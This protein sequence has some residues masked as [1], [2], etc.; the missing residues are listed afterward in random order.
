ML[1]AD[2][3]LVNDQISFDSDFKT[4]NEI[5]QWAVRAE[6]LTGSATNQRQ[7]GCGGD[8]GGRALVFVGRS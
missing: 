3:E 8:S 7:E 5:D 2:A 1:I 4:V 6:C